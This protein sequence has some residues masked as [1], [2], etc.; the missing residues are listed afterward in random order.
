[1]YKRQVTAVCSGKNEDFVRSLGAD[2]VIDYTKDDPEN[3]NRQ[4]DIVFDVIGNLSFRKIKYMLYDNGVLVSTLPNF[5]SIMGRV[6]SF[7]PQRYRTF[8]TS[9]SEEGIAELA[10]MLSENKII[11]VVDRSFPLEEISAAHKYSE[12]MRTKGKIIIKID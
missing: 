7:A 5:K 2:D 12:S 6:F 11:P 1:V 4:F 3:L 9:V 8:I 10:L